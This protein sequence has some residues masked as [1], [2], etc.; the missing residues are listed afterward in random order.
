MKSSECVPN[1]K[2]NLGNKI[3]RY[4]GIAAIGLASMA[5]TANAQKSS[6]MEQDITRV[7][8]LSGDFK[9]F[10][11]NIFRE[12]EGKKE[13]LY[14][15][16]N[17]KDGKEQS[18]YFESDNQAIRWG[19]E[20]FKPLSPDAQQDLDTE[21]AFQASGLV[22]PNGNPN[23]KTHIEERFFNGYGINVKTRVLVDE[24]GKVVRLLEKTDVP[25]PK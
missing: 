6:N 10:R 20:Y 9:V 15:I 5:G 1:K 18:E 16:K 19:P 3:R 12:S 17:A 14:I 13:F 24:H 7:E 22:A 25:F 11:T 23:E 4:T 2:S 8:L 21:R